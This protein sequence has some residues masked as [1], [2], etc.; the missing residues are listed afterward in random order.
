MG[1]R[2]FLETPAIKRLVGLA[3]LCAL[4]LIGGKLFVRGP[5]SV[6]VVYELGPEARTVRALTA[7]WRR[8][9]DA[10]GTPGAMALRKRYNF[11]A[12]GAPADVHHEVRLAKGSYAVEV[13]LERAGG[14]ETRARTV[15]IQ[16]DGD[17]I[18]IDLQR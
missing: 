8:L 11:G 3:L 12:E 10:G 9:P 13:T 2:A 18:R 15:E 4:V 17:I 7:T 6:D 1:L 14:T 16:H 5:V